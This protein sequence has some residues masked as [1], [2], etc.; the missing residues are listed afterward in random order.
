MIKLSIFSL[1]HQSAVKNDVIF[2]RTWN[3][4][5]NHSLKHAS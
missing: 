2:D 1:L 4:K 5:L 3:N